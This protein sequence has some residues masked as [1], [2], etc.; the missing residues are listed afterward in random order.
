MSDGSFH[1]TLYIVITVTIKRDYPA[2]RMNAVIVARLACLSA[3]LSAWLA[4]RT[5]HFYAN[6]S[7]VLASYF[8]W[9]CTTVRML[10]RLSCSEFRIARTCGDT[11]TDSA[12]RP[13]DDCTRLQS[14]DS[15]LIHLSYG[16][17]ATVSR[18]KRK[19]DT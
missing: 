2:A 13:A 16:S 5:I 11:L 8:S 15:H 1:D 7:K 3:V 19:Q 18:N 9:E 14:H 12:I 10:I 6:E 4:I 17:N